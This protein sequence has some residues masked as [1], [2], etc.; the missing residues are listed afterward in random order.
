MQTLY[1]SSNAAEAHMLVDL[2]KQH[3]ITAEILTCPLLPCQSKVE[4][5]E[6]GN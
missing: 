4:V 3:G 1:E 2:L 6:R 5:H